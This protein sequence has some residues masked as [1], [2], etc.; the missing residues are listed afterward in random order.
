MMS[1]GTLILNQASHLATQGVF[2]LM[3]GNAEGVCIGS[4]TFDVQVFTIT[5]LIGS[6]AALGMVA[7]IVVGTGGCAAFGVELDGSAD[8][9][10]GSCILELFGCTTRTRRT[11]TLQQRTTT[12]VVSLKIF[13]CKATTQICDGLANCET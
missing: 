12:E 11:A 1:T 4:F 8:Y 13:M 10:N 5:V 3:S 7:G 2:R 6:H 9:D